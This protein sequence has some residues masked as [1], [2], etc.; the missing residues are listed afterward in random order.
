[1]P[2]PDQSEVLRQLALVRRELCLMRWLLLFVS[3]AL[4]LLL[5]APALALR[6]AEWA[7]LLLAENAAPIIGFGVTAVIIVVVAIRYSP[8]RPASSPS[9]SSAL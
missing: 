5:F 4:A 2:E 3:L 9:E 7:T 8:P 6:L 1:M